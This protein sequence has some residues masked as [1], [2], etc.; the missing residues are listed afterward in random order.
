MKTAKSW[1]IL[2]VVVVLR[3]QLQLKSNVSLE[4]IFDPSATTKNPFDYNQ[5]VVVV[6]VVEGV[7]V[8]N[9]MS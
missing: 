5:I 2:A 3:L 6:V 8:D 1:P 9:G 4:S 7:L